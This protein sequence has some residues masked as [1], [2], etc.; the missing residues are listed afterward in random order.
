MA[1]R[2][3][4]NSDWKVLLLEAGGDPSIESEVNNDKIKLFRFSFIL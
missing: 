2:L 3:S 4:E 1:S